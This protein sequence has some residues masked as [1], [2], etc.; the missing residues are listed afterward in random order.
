MRITNVWP[1][2][3]IDVQKIAIT[4]S[5]IP[6]KKKVKK[7]SKSIANGAILLF[8]LVVAINKVFVYRKYQS[9]ANLFEFFSER[10]FV[11][12]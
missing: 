9:F 7:T 11:A 6:A 3:E 10:T 12:I 4:L 2:N 5:P 1:K 8:I